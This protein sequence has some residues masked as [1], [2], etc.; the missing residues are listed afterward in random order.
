MTDYDKLKHG[1]AYYDKKK[2]AAMCLC[3]KAGIR[4]DKYDAYFCPDSGVWVEEACDNANCCY[5]PSRPSI[6]PMGSTSSSKMVLKPWMYVVIAVAY[7]VLLPAMV[8][9]PNIHALDWP[10]V[11]LGFVSGA[12]FMSCLFMAREA[13]KEYG[14]S[15]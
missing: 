14:N 9:S 5:C 11:F 13:R 6:H 10:H 3:G 4:D 1:R 2:L 12:A 8:A 15:K 7:L